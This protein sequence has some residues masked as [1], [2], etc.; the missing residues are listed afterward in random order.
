MNEQARPDK[1]PA[2][3]VLTVQDR[4]EIQDLI[5]EF[6]YHEDSGAAAAWAA[7]FT[8]GGSMTGMGKKPVVGRDDLLALATRRW[9][10]KPEA[11]GRA[12]WVCSIRIWATE[13]GAAA[14]SYQMSVDRDESGF[15]IVAVTIKADDLRKEDGRWRFQARRVLPL[16]GA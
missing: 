13:T 15:R 9:E 4:I 1:T 2:E 11:H 14:E 5:A 3:I 16:G 7:L 10:T 12:H 6:N 8:E